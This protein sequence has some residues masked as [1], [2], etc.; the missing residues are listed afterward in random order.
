MYRFIRTARP[1][2]VA[3]LA[4][5]MQWAGE[6]TAYVNKTYAIN[7]KY[8]VDLFGKGRI[9]WHFDADSLDKITG[10]NARM[11][12]DRDYQGLLA[13][14]KSLWLEGSYEDTIVAIVG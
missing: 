4:P 9:H 13:K 3:E 1:M 14:G 11:M 2:T 5:A 10:M 7:L 8:G 12:Q 6:V